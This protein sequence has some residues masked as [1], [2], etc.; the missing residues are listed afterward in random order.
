VRLEIR[1]STY[2][3]IQSL[4][5]KAEYRKIHGV[6]ERIPL[7]GIAKMTEIVCAIIG[8]W[9]AGEVTPR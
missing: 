6:D 3:L 7:A 4:L 8:R 2:S 1:I 9:N 5:P